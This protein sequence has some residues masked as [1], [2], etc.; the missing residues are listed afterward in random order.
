MGSRDR[1]IESKAQVLAVEALNGLGDIIR[2]LNRITHVGLKLY[3]VKKY[4]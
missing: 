4:I 3:I 2:E 1:L